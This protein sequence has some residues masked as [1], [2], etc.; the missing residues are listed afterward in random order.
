[1]R[2]YGEEV[3]LALSFDS[4]KSTDGETAGLLYAL[5]HAES[6]EE[7]REKW[8]YNVYAKAENQ[9]IEN[10]KNLI[11]KWILSIPENWGDDAT[12]FLK[13]CSF[14]EDEAL[15]IIGIAQTYNDKFPCKHGRRELYDKAINEVSWDNWD[16]G[17]YPHEEI[18][19]LPLDILLRVWYHATF[20]YICVASIEHEIK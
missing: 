19:A 7:A 4:G 6:L 18:N 1:M 14:T 17:A 5:I 3:Y 11:V 20:R 15:A 13:G 2:T 16:K 10:Y 12:K 8:F 9:D